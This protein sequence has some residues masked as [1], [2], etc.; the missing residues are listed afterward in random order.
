MMYQ[1]SEAVRLDYLGEATPRREQR[2]SFEVV[3]GAGLDHLERRGVSP[4]FIANLKLAAAV[5]VALV[6]LCVARIGVYSMAVGTLASNESMRSELKQTVALEDDLRIQRSVLSSTHRID[7]IATQSYGMVAA[8]GAEKLS[9][10]DSADSAS[11]GTADEAT[12]AQATD[13]APDATQAQ[14][15]SDEV[16]SEV[17]QATQTQG[18]GSTAGANAADVDSL[19]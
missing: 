18:D 12:D 4:Q 19:S 11:E 13:A 5:C 16:A 2:T 15:S 17:G 3:E 14:K 6:V 7:R 9:V 1:G 10:S 8:N